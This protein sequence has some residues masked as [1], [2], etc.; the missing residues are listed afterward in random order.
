MNFLE[1]AVAFDAIERVLNCFATRG[2]A[3][4]RPA[5]QT[6]SPIR[7]GDIVAARTALASFLEA[8]DHGAAPVTDG[9]TNRAAVALGKLGGRVRSDKKAAAARKNGKKGGRPPKSKKATTT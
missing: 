4:T 8:T 7:V 9:E 5:P 2:M 6:V 3:D 1:R